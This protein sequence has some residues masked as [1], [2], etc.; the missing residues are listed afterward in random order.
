[1][2]IFTFVIAGSFLFLGNTHSAQADTCT[3]SAFAE[4]TDANKAAPASTPTTTAADCDKYCSGLSANSYTF[5]AGNATGTTLNKSGDASS[6]AIAASVAPTDP[7]TCELMNPASWIFCLML[8]ILKFFSWILSA[9]AALFIWSADANSL[10]NVINGQGIYS[11]WGIVR[12]LLNMAFIMVLLY[13]AFCTIFQI[14][15]YNYKKMLLTIVLMALLV[16]FS[17]PIARFIIDVGN[18]L[19][20][21]IFNSLFSGTDPNGILTMFSKNS[22]IGTII[23]GTNSSSPPAQIVGATVFVAILAITFLMMAILFFIRIVALALVII[24]SPIAFVGAAV[25]GLKSLSSKWWDYIFKYTFFGPAMAFMLYIA[26]VII[27]TTIAVS[28]TNTAFS[29]FTG[30]FGP[31][32]N[33]ISSMANFAIPI[34]VLWIGMNVAQKM[35]IEGAAMA[36]KLATKAFK[37]VAMAPVKAAQWGVNKTG[38][39]GGVKKGWEEVRKTGRL[40]GSNNKL[41]NFAFKNGQPDREAKIAGGV[42]GGREGFN[43]ATDN[44]RRKKIA[45][46]TKAYEEYNTSESQMVLDL[47]STDE[48]TRNAAG[49]MLAKKKLIKD[50]TRLAAVLAAVSDPDTQTDILD[51]TPQV[52]KTD[53]ELDSVYKSL[54]G[55]PAKNTELRNKIDSEIKKDNN[56]KI[57]IDHDINFKG[58]AH[59]KAYEDRL[60]NLSGEDLGKQKNLHEDIDTNPD[61]QNFVLTNLAPNK[62]MHQEAFRRMS[63]KQQAAY[64]NL[65]LHP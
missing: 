65:G 44:L 2:A 33:I 11:T 18:T 34:V 55:N 7:D 13:V 52:I 60:G 39:P 35:G 47:K 5:G 41:V 61:L 19:M 53:N 1:M 29:S 6:T 59:N 22:G 8:M 9:A 49:I 40:F 50:G 10:T 21:T 62:V 17:F 20:Y 64:I 58:T 48:I 4:V 43:A 42:S 54:K 16:N 24:F 28:T 46:K 56:V 15:S 51:K 12:D 37:A 57:L 3:C 26:T 25:P 27:K 63:S 23:Q 38:V 14:D 32:K 31:D 30:G 45:E 36:Q